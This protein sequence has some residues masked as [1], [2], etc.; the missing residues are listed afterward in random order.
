MARQQPWADWIRRAR[1]EVDAWDASGDDINSDTAIALADLVGTILA[2]L[3]TLHTDPETARQL[4]DQLTREHGLTVTQPDTEHGPL[5]L[6]ARELATVLAALRYWQQ[7]L[8]A[9]A[10][11]PI[12]EH[13]TEVAPLSPDEIDALCEAL[14][15]QPAPIAPPASLAP[16]YQA[17]LVEAQRE[18]V[19]YLRVCPYCGD[20]AVRLI[21]FTGSCDIR[22]SEDGWALTDGPCDTS[23]ER[24]LCST[25]RHPVDSRFVLVPDPPPDTGDST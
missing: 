10:E 2:Q 8:A 17:A 20:D 12:S 5:T 6:A 24:F 1:Q 23:D 19:Q 16:A 18:G 14:N 15:T 25:C 11:P 13:F 9:N 21:G 4:V 3:Q 22:I 7:D